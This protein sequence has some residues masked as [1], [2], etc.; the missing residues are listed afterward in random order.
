M[1]LVILRGNECSDYEVRCYSDKRK[2]ERFF[3]E[4]LDIWERI[5]GDACFRTTTRK[6]IE[7]N[8]SIDL[9][10]CSGGAINTFLKMQI[11]EAVDG[12]V[13]SL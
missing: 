7:E 13:I 2:A 1:W 6:Q 10:W 11:E 5:Y 12:K 9:Y 8:L 4:E 3:K